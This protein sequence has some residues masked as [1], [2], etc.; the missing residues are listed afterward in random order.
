MH[1][2]RVK[3]L[4]GALFA[5]FLLV[6]LVNAHGDH[7]HGHGHRH[8]AHPDLDDLE[9]DETT[10]IPSSS[11]ESTP[12]KAVELPTF[13]VHPPPPSHAMLIIS[14]SLQL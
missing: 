10:T 1:S 3:L 6:T 14:F 12:V 7:G 13:T 8:P 4:F 2:S 11:P 9:E 5:V